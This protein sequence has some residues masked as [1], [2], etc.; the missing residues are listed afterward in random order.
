MFTISLEEWK[1]LEWFDSGIEYTH[2]APD[3]LWENDY[4]VVGEFKIDGISLDS[5]PEYLFA[6]CFWLSFFLSF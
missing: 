6:F 1:K 2:F 4:S 5:F 3:C